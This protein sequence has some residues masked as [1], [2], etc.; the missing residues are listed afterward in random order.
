MRERE[1]QALGVCRPSPR[2][3]DFERSKDKCTCL[4]RPAREVPAQRGVDETRATHQGGLHP[5]TSRQGLNEI[6]RFYRL[7]KKEK[8]AP[9]LSGKKVHVGRGMDTVPAGPL[10]FPF[11]AFFSPLQIGRYDSR[12]DYEYRTY[13]E[14]EHQEDEKI[15][16]LPD[17]GKRSQIVAGEQDT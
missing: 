2:H 16:V 10:F 17:N 11:T 6:F 7:S 1:G 15:H 8:F 9:A 13:G 3:E 5:I 14:E 12:K 4:T